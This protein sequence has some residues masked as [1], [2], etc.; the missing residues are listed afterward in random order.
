MILHVKQ[1]T[2]TASE[3]KCN[4]VACCHF[5]A[6]ISWFNCNQLHWS[7]LIQKFISAEAQ[8][9]NET[10][11]GHTSQKKITTTKESMYYFWQ[12]KRN[13]NHNGNE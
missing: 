8:W 11:E 9:S 5:L 7:C 6:S 4:F 13:E 12:Q 3:E 2:K 1:N 10:A